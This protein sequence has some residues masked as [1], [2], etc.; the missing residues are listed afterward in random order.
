MSAQ[1]IG[2]FSMTASEPLCE[3]LPNNACRE[4]ATIVTCTM[5]GLRHAPGSSHVCVSFFGV[6]TFSFVI[7]K[8]NLQPS[9]RTSQYCPVAITVCKGNHYSA[10]L[11]E[12]SKLLLSPRSFSFT[13]PLRPVSFRGLYPHLAS[14]IVPRT[15]C[16]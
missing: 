5:Q 9:D 6:F 15:Q 1:P 14:R 12:K 3:S 7:S 10:N 8:Y 16:S 13:L 2:V 11:S 4:L